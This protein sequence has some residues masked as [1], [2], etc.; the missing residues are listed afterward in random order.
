ME[1]AVN[2]ARHHPQSAEV[3][4][5][6][7]APQIATHALD[8]SLVHKNVEGAYEVAGIVEYECFPQYERCGYGP[9]GGCGHVWCSVGVLC[10]ARNSSAIT[11]AVAKR[12]F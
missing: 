2:H 8:G 3:V 7:L 10:A 6:R 11:A 12:H 9:R 4:A 5:F 1:M